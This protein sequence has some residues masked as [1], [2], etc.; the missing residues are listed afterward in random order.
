VTT[1]ARP[2]TAKGWA[3]PSRPDLGWASARKLA[4]THGG[5]LL[6]RLRR[7]WQGVGVRMVALDGTKMRAVASAKNIAGAERL[8]RDIVHT[9]MEIAH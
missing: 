8:A 3:P 9:E 6:R 4:D 1:L 5:H 7:H 2:E